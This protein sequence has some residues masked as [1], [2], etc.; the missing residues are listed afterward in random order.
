M[1]IEYFFGMPRY[2][3]SYPLSADTFTLQMISKILVLH[4]GT[5]MYDKAFKKAVE[6]AEFKVPFKKIN[7]KSNAAKFFY[8][9]S[10]PG[11]CA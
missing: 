3:S 6:L 2:L 5:E 10:G 9:L 1:L 7:K 11:Q 4:D 8:L